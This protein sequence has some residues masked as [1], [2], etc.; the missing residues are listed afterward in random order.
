[1]ASK[2]KTVPFNR[3]PC[4]KRGFTEEGADKALGRART[5]RHR[6]APDGN[7]R[8]LR[9]ENRTYLCDQ[10][11]GDVWHLTEQSRRQFTTYAQPP[12]AVA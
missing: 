1:M 8:G 2:N 3:C 5:K 7:R 6:S 9:V 12:M 4:G 11:N 10:A